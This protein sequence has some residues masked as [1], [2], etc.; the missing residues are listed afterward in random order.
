VRTT[1]RMLASRRD[2]RLVLAAGLVSDAGDWIL[3][4]GLAYRVYAITGSTV[5]SALTMA[6]SCAPRVLLG[7]VAGVFADR[8]DRRR[9]MITADLLLAVAL[10]PLLLVHGAGRVWIVFVVMFAEGAIAQFFSPAEQ[11]LVP[12]LV[13]D[14]ELVAANALSGQ[15]SNSSRLV[16]SALG[17]IL[18]AAAGL[19]AVALADAASFVA[20]AVLLTLVRASGRAA[21][22]A[23]SPAR[24]G[25]GAAVRERIAEIGE[26]L[27]D[28]LRLSARHRVLRTL[29]IFALVTS[30][31]EGI[32]ST[33]FTPFVEHVLHGSSQEFGLVVAAQAV[34]GI[35]GG[36][37]AAG[38]GHRVRA[39]RLLGW[40]ALVFGL[41][42]LA[43]F[44]YPLGYVAVW[45][46]VVGMVVVGLPGAL[47][48]AG[49]ITL[50]QRSTADS[51][52]GRVFGA[53]SA[54]EGVTVLAG[55]LGA[56]FLSRYA[57]IVPVLA[58]QGA[59]YV[60]A[61][62]AMLAWLRGGAGEFTAREPEVHAVADT[63]QAN[64]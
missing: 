23:G 29:M 55:T 31:G 26:E 1:W 49:L 9:T 51:H 4:I 63:V 59:G 40:G 24:A 34:G 46:A 37:L 33:L 64:A 18:A 14:E 28:G 25:S 17:G 6:S 62:L 8:W 12:T 38:F 7:A 21:A 53:L 61:G 50:F 48:M 58:I 13:P 20:S 41:V 57:G 19:G 16:G 30:V 22:V 15:V 56:G 39:S 11:A 60:V 27:R 36:V 43:I 32:M 54:L 42:D 10:L 47:T 3:I 2:L 35:L 5:A 52:R 45:P 44:L